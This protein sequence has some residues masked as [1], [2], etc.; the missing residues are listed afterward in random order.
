MRQKNRYQGGN[1]AFRYRKN[2]KERSIGDAKQQ[3]RLSVI[4]AKRAQ[5]MSLRKIREF[6]KVKDGVNVPHNVV[7]QLLTGKCKAAI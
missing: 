2:S 5:G 7:D 6:V 1:V 3:W 4:G